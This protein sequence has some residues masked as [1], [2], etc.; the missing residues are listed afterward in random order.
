MKEEVI[1]V[2]WSTKDELKAI[3][4][5]A[6]GEE[7]IGSKFRPTLKERKAKLRVYIETAM[8]R[9]WAQNVDREACIDL[10]NDLYSDLAQIKKGAVK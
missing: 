4:Y 1:V 2:P 3:A 9:V 5:I 6:N 10:A 8:K 7:R